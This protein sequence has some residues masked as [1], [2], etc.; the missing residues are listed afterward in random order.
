MLRQC[1]FNNYLEFGHIRFGPFGHLWRYALFGKKLFSK[2]GLI[3][4]LISQISS[5]RVG[6]LFPLVLILSVQSYMLS[7]ISKDLGPGWDEWG[8][9]SSGLSHWETGDWAAYRVNPPLVRL[10]AALPGFVLG[11][12]TRLDFVRSAPGDRPEWIL[13]ERFIQ[14]N[15][16]RGLTLVSYGRLVVAVFSV[17][18][19]VLLFLTAFRLYGLFQA[20]SAAALWAFSPICLAFG[21][22]ITPDVAATVVGIP[23]AFALA[24]YFRQPE[25]LIYS[26]GLGACLGVAVLTKF[27][28]FPFLLV[29]PSLM[30]IWGYLKLGIT[31]RTLCAPAIVAISG[32]FI[33][34]AGYVFD[35]TGTPLREFQFVS[36]TL[37]GTEKIDKTSGNRFQNLYLGRVPVP[38]PFQFVM[39]LDQQR[40]DFEAG[41]PSYLLG[42]WKMG[43]WW[44]YYL[45]G[46]AIKEPLPFVVLIIIGVGSLWRKNRYDRYVEYSFFGLALGM[47]VLVSSQTGFNHHLRYILPCWPAMIL[48]SVRWIDRGYWRRIFVMTG[49]LVQ[50]LSSW[51]ILPW[52]Y[53]YFSPIVGGTDQGWRCM[54][55]SNLD[56]GQDIITLRKWV[57]ANP[58]IRP[59]NVLY[60]SDLFDFSSLGINAENRSYS[61]AV[62]ADENFVP[63]PPTGGWW[64]V[65][66]DKL[67]KT[68]G[69]WFRTQPRIQKISPS[70]DLYYVTEAA[71]LNGSEN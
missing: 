9:I 38:L 2:E 23:L 25:R 19:T 47:L 44:Y 39:G 55:E 16:Q 61:H 22:C 63:P 41:Y 71:R 11:H 65:C 52:N 7:R 27:S 8:H 3:G 12:E 40:Y 32:L 53:A 68:E 6:R 37:T 33:I 67:A 4:C 15:G 30:L 64:I 34:N 5:T 36:P 21:G 51:F 13:A 56:W 35:G 59:L 58:D 62:R 1:V 46:I 66:K 29:I 49:V 45:V 54:T 70:F 24:F 50:L 60:F 18:G 14:S 48:L 43:G 17:G 10:M 42:E 28:W 26:I 31:W 69:R 20:F 57:D